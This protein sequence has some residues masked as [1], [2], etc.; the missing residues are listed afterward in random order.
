MWPQWCVTMKD[1]RLRR[2]NVTIYRSRRDSLMT[3]YTRYVL[4]PQPDTPAIDLPHVVVL[5][6]FPPFRDIIKASEGT[7]MDAK[8]AQ[9]PVLVGEWRGNMMLNLPS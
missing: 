1:F 5:V 2:L 8:P 7:Q 4:H 9:L 3:E 6:S